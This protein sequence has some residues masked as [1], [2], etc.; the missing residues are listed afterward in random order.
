VRA[1][2][3]ELSKLEVDALV[4]QG[5][6]GIYEIPGNEPYEGKLG[7]GRVDLW[8]TWLETPAAASVASSSGRS[9]V[10]CLRLVPNPSRTD[11]SVSVFLPLRSRSGV[12]A[13]GPSSVEIL[14]VTGRRVRRLAYGDARADGV[15]WDGRDEAGRSLPPGIY[16]TRLRE[17]DARLAGAS[18]LVRLP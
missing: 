12:G 3:P 8:R 11:Q 2:A 10:D 6:A 16:F 14:D 15:R 13:K 17:G 1:L 18:S 9:G 4:R 7:S 5:V